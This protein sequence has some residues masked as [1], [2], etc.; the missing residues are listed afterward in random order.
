MAS[1]R[2]TVG[3]LWAHDADLVPDEAHS[4][5]GARGWRLLI[6]A[7]S[8]LG[9]VYGDIGTSPLYVFAAIFPD[10]APADSNI[11]LGAA[12]SIIWSITA[13][14]LVKYVLFTLSANDNGQGGVFALYAL[15]CRATGI[16]GGGTSLVHEADLSLRQYSSGTAATPAAGSAPS[17]ATNGGVASRACGVGFAAKWNRSR[18]AVADRARAALARSSAAQTALLVVTLMAATMIL[19]DGVLT[20]AISVVSAIEGIEYN[21]GITQSTVVGISVAILV[22]LFALQPFGTQRIAFMFSPLVLLWFATNTGLGIYNMI[23][24]GFGACKALSPHYIYYFWAGR[25]GDAWRGL[26][27]ILLSVTGAE[28]LYADMGHFSAGAIRLS[29]VGLVYPSLAFT[30]LGQTAMILARP[31]T[32]SAAYWQ[33]VPNS[34]Q[35]PVVAVATCAAIIASQALISGSFT[36]AQQA[37]SLNAFPRLTVRHTSEKIMGQVYV[38]AVN[39][40]LM[41]ACVA[42]VAAFKSSAKIGNAYGLAV[43]TVMLLDTSLLAAVMVLAWGWSLL[44]AAAFWLPF[45]V[46]TGAFFSSTL[47]KVPKGAWFSLVLSGILAALTF[48]WHWGQSMKLQHVRRRRLLLSS[49]LQ[50]DDP[51]AALATPLLLAAAPALD[52]EKASSV[53]RTSV[54]ST[55]SSSK[56]SGARALQDGNRLRLVDSGVPVARVPGLG[57]YY[58]ELLRGVPPVLE[59]YMSLLPAIHSVVI[60]LTVRMVPVPRVLPSERL[61]I[62]RLHLPGFYHA[63]SRYGYMEEADH[64]PAFVAGL[65]QE[66]YEY[67]HP[68]THLG[69]QAEAG[70]TASPPPTSLFP[71]VGAT[72]VGNA[73]GGEP[74]LEMGMVGSQGGMQ[75]GGLVRVDAADSLTAATG[76]RLNRQLSM[77]LVQLSA[78]HPVSPQNTIH[79]RASGT[80]PSAA[81]IT[82]AVA[83][84]EGGPGVSG[85]GREEWEADDDWDWAGERVEEVTVSAPWV[86]MPSVVRRV[87]AQMLGQPPPPPA[88]A[89]IALWLREQ[90]VA[91]AATHSLPLPAQL[92]RPRLP[93]R[94]ASSAARPDATASLP[95]PAAPPRPVLPPSLLDAAPEGALG[96][97][98]PT[99]SPAPTTDSL[100]P[101]NPAPTTTLRPGAASSLGRQLWQR[102]H[103]QGHLG[104]APQL[105]AEGGSTRLMAPTPTA[106]E[107]EAGEARRLLF[108]IQATASTVRGGG[109]TGGGTCGSTARYALEREALLRA[110]SEGV[111][112]VVG[113][114]ALRAA[115][116]SGL[117]KRLLLEGAYGFLAA[118]CRPSSAAWGLPPAG[119]LQVGVD[120]EV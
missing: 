91:A 35:W 65:V 51:G 37:I 47:E 115:P 42:V 76:R 75:L 33:S 53:A 21:T 55:T 57:I 45:T 22:V 12:S 99:N 56:V 46:I 23:L 29:F 9:I 61:L 62:R 113:R 39:W 69:S 72:D 104:A 20:P 63:V 59:R 31:D 108:D 87:R 114:S 64:G 14:V 97:P 77:Q 120:Y 25:A 40:C 107:G 68:M 67:L 101:T 111:V 15:L 73:A 54:T 38:P 90:E 85:V 50:R 58:T 96:G 6:M 17:E 117:I 79:S 30:Y 83:V 109:S 24:H 34:L 18:L 95:L 86:Q 3:S 60:F 44:S 26:G 118:A 116:D 106:A 84:A 105:E 102:L 32:S 92:A 36:I 52:S 43:V 1:P 82:M 5:H 49:V 70:G 112:Y 7:F 28:A 94:G 19:S 2:V 89:A 119:L 41:V 80:R 100:A 74:D 16:Q 66:I 11:V 88:A 103:G 110:Q 4:R 71:S 98:A 8:T 10:G 81:A 27:A 13:I 78:S 48:L 93:P